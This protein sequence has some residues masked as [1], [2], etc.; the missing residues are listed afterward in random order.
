M[1]HIH[2]NC[3]QQMARY[4]QDVGV[5]IILP[6]FV[7]KVPKVN[8]GDQPSFHHKGFNVVGDGIAEE[9]IKTRDSNLSRSNNQFIPLLK[10]EMTVTLMIMEILFQ[11]IP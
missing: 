3:V 1:A 9:D 7:W 8:N 5:M 6:K 2:G 11:F 10:M 4:A